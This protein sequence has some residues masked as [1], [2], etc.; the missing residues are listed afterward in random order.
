ML[1]GEAWWTGPGVTGEAMLVG[2]DGVVLI[3]LP[4]GIE[5]Y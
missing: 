4:L 3:R 1:N 5:F 2:P